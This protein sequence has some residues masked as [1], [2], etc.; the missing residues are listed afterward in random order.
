MGS[1][2][3]GRRYCGVRPLVITF[4]GVKL[5]FHFC[6][7]CQ[8]AADWLFDGLCNKKRGG[9]LESLGR[10]PQVDSRQVVGAFEYFIGSG[11]ICSRDAGEVFASDLVFLHEKLE[12]LLAVSLGE[13]TRC[14]ILWASTSWLRGHK[15]IS[16]TSR[17]N[18]SA[19]PAG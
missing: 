19:R 8:S 1:G 10:A 14:S 2:P 4:S 3:Q 16:T 17:S 5:A 6:N 18:R 11:A 13:G 12:R 15:P 9:D 7:P